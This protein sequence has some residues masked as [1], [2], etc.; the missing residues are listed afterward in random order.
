M[1][2]HGLQV[3]GTQLQNTSLTIP[4]SALARITTTKSWPGTH[5][6]KF[7]P[8]VMKDNEKQPGQHVYFLE[9]S[10]LPG[11]KKTSEAALDRSP[12]DLRWQPSLQTGHLLCQQL[13]KLQIQ[14]QHL[15]LNISIPSRTPGAAPKVP[16]RVSS[17]T[18][19][20]QMLQL[21]WLLTQQMSW[22]WSARGRRPSVGGRGHRPAGGRRPT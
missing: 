7:R 22:L 9:W 20:C 21:S 18:L 12:R 16:P 15:K 10:A 19:R 17:I 8:R 6:V 13:R 3:D 11:V 14:L 2:L 4:T 1:V 5:W